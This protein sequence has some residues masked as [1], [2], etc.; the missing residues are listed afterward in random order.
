MAGINDDEETE[1]PEEILLREARAH[2]RVTSGTD[3]G[4]IQQKLDAAQAYVA[5]YI[6]R[7]VRDED[8]TMP[9]ALKEAVFQCAAWFYDGTAP[10]VGGLLAPYRQTWG[11]A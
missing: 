7:P 4:L 9:P 11:M 6:G 3:D 8:G 10:D 1:T 2:L 5:D